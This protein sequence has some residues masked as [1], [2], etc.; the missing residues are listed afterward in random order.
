MFSRIVVL[1]TDAAIGVEKQGEDG[2]VFEFGKGI[3]FE[4]TI[5]PSVIKGMERIGV[6]RHTPPE[7]RLALVK[8]LLVLWEGVSNVRLVW[9]PSAVEAL[10]N[11]IGSVASCRHIKSDMRARL[12]RALLGSM[13]KTNVIKNLGLICAIP[14]DSEKM[15]ELSMEAARL[16]LEQWA[17]SGEEDTERRAAIL[18]SLGNIASNG[19]L[20]HGSERVKL[21]RDTV[22]ET[23]FEGLR[24]GVFQV[25][26]PLEK[27]CNCSGLDPSQRSEIQTRLQRAY[28]LVKAEKKHQ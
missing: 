12:G 9:S 28:G 22:I 27:L 11:A 3:Y 15:H 4:T 25:K 10:A 23:L 5:I 6:G 20:E 7:L 21:M 18:I 1:Q 26:E 17:R 13:N 16:L 8:R 2:P 24:G 14:V 19:G